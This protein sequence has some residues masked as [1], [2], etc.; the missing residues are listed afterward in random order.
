MG[1]WK[2]GVKGVFLAIFVQVLGV[3][4]ILNRQINGRFAGVI[5]DVLLLPVTTIH[6]LQ[7]NKLQTFQSHL[8]NLCI[9]FFSAVFIFQ[10]NLLKAQVDVRRRTVCFERLSC[11]RIQTFPNIHDFDHVSSVSAYL[12]VCLRGTTPRPFVTYRTNTTW[13]LSAD[14][15]RFQTAFPL[16]LTW[17][18][19][20]FGGV[21]FEGGGWWWG[22]RWW[23]WCRWWCWVGGQ[24]TE[25]NE[26][27]SLRAH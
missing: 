24:V 2:H 13:K 21:Y 17:H 5:W 6:P 25:L 12:S 27:M 18:S 23:R 22:W 20:G 7:R 8:S 11:L 26:N 3:W 9:E 1:R 19:A 16:R 10:F 14:C 15:L 4:N